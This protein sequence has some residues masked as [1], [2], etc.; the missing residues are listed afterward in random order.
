MSSATPSDNTDTE[1]EQRR[2]MLQKNLNKTKSQLQINIDTFGD[3][4]I[5]NDFPD[6]SLFFADHDAVLVMGGIDPHVEYGAPGNTGKDMYRYK[7]REN[8]W[9]F[10]GE[11]PEPRHHHSV[12]YLCGRVYLV[13][14]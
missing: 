9:E 2:S 8:I 5:N 10:V 3:A 14:K 4:S 12:A 13:G 11:I 6:Y 7:S 1:I